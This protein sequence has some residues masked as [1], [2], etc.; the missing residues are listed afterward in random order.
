VFQ[1]LVRPVI[2]RMSGRAAA[3]A[4]TVRA[5]AGMRL[6]SAKGR[7]TFVMVKLRKNGSGRVVADVVE[8]GAS[9]AITTLAKADGYVEIP[10]NQQFVDKD[11]EVEVVLF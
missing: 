10:E 3:R 7:R 4:E 11:E 8:T 2:W 5:L 1:L 6:F 9:G